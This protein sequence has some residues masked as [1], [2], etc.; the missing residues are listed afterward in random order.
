MFSRKTIKKLVV[1]AL[2]TT[3]CL[4]SAI[5]AFAVS[6][7]WKQDSTGWWYSYSD[8]TY[9]KKKWVEIDKNYYYFDD[10]GYMVE[11]QYRDGYWVDEN[12]IRSSKYRGGVWK[13]DKTGK[14][15]EDT[16]GYYP[17]SCWLVI[18]GDYYY[19]DNSGYAQVNKWVD[20]YYLD[21]DGKWVKDAKFTDF[22][23]TYTESIAGRG[24]ITIKN[25]YD[26][27]YSIEVKWS[28]SASDLAEWKMNGTFDSNG[29]MTYKD[30]TKTLYT[31]ASDGSSTSK[32][33]Y[34][35]GTGTIKIADGKLSWDDKKEG[36]A[37]DSTFVKQEEFDVKGFDYSGSY[38]EPTL[39]RA[40]VTIKAVGTEGDYNVTIG[41]PDENG[42][43]DTYS[44]SGKFDKDG[45]LS[46]NNLVKNHEEYKTDGT[47]ASKI[48]FKNGIGSITYKDKKLTWDNIH[49]DLQYT[50]FQLI[51]Q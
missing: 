43:M 45:K 35:D 40:N 23:G 28:G 4:G 31:Y 27:N 16:T 20:G 33:I 25:V 13:T 11:K 38:E 32:T 34:S 22:S 21:K 10:N 9:A 6:G 3:M 49:E 19:F 39:H 48:I 47:S 41:Y 51:E 12:G 46:Y 44:F 1:A 24:V 15:F 18:D 8:G 42:N 36:I 7:T 5:T 17:T 14:W 30:C 50:V 29:N 26:M 2:A 37:K